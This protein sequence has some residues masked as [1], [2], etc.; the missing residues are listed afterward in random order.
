M[1]EDVDVEQALK[2]LPEEDMNL[3]V[4]RI[5]RAMDLSLKHTILP[6]E[7]W[8]KPEEVSGF[9]NTRKVCF[10]LKAQTG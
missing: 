5:K 3:R 4:F 10:T 7:H 6:E 2:R 8:T 9:S 1:E